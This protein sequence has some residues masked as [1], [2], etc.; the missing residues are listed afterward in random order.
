[1]MSE[2]HRQLPVTLQDISIKRSLTGLSKITLRICCDYSN[3]HFR[4]QVAPTLY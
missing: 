2:V 4:I 1:M 3:D